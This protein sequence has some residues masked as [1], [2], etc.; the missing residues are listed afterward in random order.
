M[1]HIDLEKQKNKKKIC[2]LKKFIL[3]FIKKATKMKNELRMEV[4]NSFIDTT[5][6]KFKRYL[7]LKRNKVFENISK[8]SSLVYKPVVSIL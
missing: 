5:S 6:Q 8:N 7:G 3:V 4:F 1:K 2:N